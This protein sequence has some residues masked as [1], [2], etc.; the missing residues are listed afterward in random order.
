MLVSKWTVKVSQHRATTVTLHQ[1]RTSGFSLDQPTLTPPMKPV[2]NGSKNTLGTTKTFW[3]RQ[4][5][6]ATVS[7]KLHPFFYTLIRDPKATALNFFPA[8]LIFAFVGEVFSIL[9]YLFTWY[10]VFLIFL[11]AFW[12]GAVFVA[13]SMSFPG[14]LSTV[15]R[16]IENQSGR[17]YKRLH[18]H[19]LSQLEKFVDSAVEAF[20]GFALAGVLRG[21]GEFG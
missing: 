17:Q 20:F 19:Y 14:Y 1:Q 12:Y 11:G 15:Q 13:R 5:P 4:W 3:Q 9:A 16:Q 21:E 7:S 18:E 8:T 10:G 6:Y 2:A